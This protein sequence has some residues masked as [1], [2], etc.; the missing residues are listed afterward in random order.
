MRKE[1]KKVIFLT[2]AT[3]LIGSYLLKLLLEKGHKVFCLA[4][5]KN[6]KSAEERVIEILNFWSKDISFDP[7][8]LKILEGDITKKNLGLNKKLL[9]LLK[10][11]V[12]QIFHCAAVTKFN[13][14]LDEIRK[15]NVEGT[16]NVL[17]LGV[18][19]SKEGK[20][21]RVNHLS[22]AYVCG[23]YKGVFKEDDLDVGQKFNTT[24]EQSKFEAEK[25]VEKY[26]KKG[27]WIDIFRPPIVVGESTTGK[28]LS[29]NLAF[30]Q[31]IRI[32]N[33]E[34]FNYCPGKSNYFFNIVFI[35]EL[36][37]SIYKIS[38]KSSI[39]NKTYHTFN[40]NR[41]SLKK[42]ID[43]SSEF[44]KFKKPKLI[45]TTEFFKKNLTMIQKNLL[46]YNFFFYNSRVRLDS[47]MTNEYLKKYNFEF[48]KF[49]RK[50]FFNLLEYAVRKGFLKKK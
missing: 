35:N 50:L 37:E 15:V 20:L 17:E 33:Q 39:R 25:V 22:T 30:Y 13:W 45:S 7:K 23:D 18:K 41:V 4:R 2:G 47:K 5:S 43:D 34:L 6:E 14:P 8:N 42:I 48:S 24:Y 1:S 36:C 19:W 44:L 49:N 11:E 10:K 32:W 3:G 9:N 38:S 27:L 16:R 31:A 12:D 40:P 28:I 21:E 46:R 29:F 26:R